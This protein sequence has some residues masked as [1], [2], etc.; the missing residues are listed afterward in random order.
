LIELL[1]IAVLRYKKFSLKQIRY[2]YERGQELFGEHPFATHQ[3]SVA[4][5]GIFEKRQA[6]AGVMEDLSSGRLAFEQILKPLLQHIVTYEGER[7]KEL[8]P[9]GKERSVILNPA[10]SY[11][12]PV[13]RD[14]GVQTS[15]L[16]GMW[17]AEKQNTELV[18]SWYRVPVGGVEDA[19]EYETALLQAA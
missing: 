17:K 12:S 18:A 8:N 15:I 7:S 19:V 1:T 4:G 13:N 9:L 5:G 10:W 16:Y 2:A 11:G 14:T 6:Y 3:Y